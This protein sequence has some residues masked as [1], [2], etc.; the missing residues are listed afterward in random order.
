MLQTLLAERLGLVTHRATTMQ[1]VYGLVVSRAGAKLAPAKATKD[2][3]TANVKVLG[4]NRGISGGV[5]S[6]TK[7]GPIKLS[8][9]DDVLHYE[10]AQMSLTGLAQFLSLG[11][12][13]LPVVDM[14]GL[15]GEY[16]ITFRYLK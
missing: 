6:Q 3:S 16:D 12:V 11:Q 8:M 4:D 1:P 15:K 2:E 14:T 7:W 5:S 10:Y 9:T 13:G